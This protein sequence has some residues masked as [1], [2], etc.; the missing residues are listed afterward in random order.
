MHVF[1][2]NAGKFGLIMTVLNALYVL[3][4]HYSGQYG[5]EYAVN[6]L[7]FLFILIVPFIVWWFGIEAKKKE[8]KG[9]LSFKDGVKE[10]FQISLVYAV[11]SPFVY[12]FYYLVLNPQILD[13]LKIE[14][15]LQGVSDLQIVFVDIL[16]QFVSAIVFGTLYAIIISFILKTKSAKR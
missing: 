15:G 10:G 16:A 13:S 2:Q 7:D 14:Y 12:A 4:M 6:P 11:L 1:S 5:P 8:K 9:K 3:F